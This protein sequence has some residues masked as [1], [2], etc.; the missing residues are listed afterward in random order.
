MIAT[1]DVV[2]FVPAVGIIGLLI[3]AYLGWSIKREK[4]GTKRMEEIAKYI[5]EGANAFLK[6]QYKT[7]SIFIVILTIIIGLTLGFTQAIAFIFGSLLSLLAAYIGINVAVRANVR[8]ANAAR[9]SPKKAFTLAFKGG[10]VMG[11][12]VV[13]LSL[14]GISLLYLVFEK[15]ELIVGFGFGASL[16]ALF[17]QLGGGIYTKA[18]DVGADLVGKVEAHIPED[19]PRNPAVIADQVGD[20]VGDCAGRGAD[21]FESFSDNIICAMILGVLFASLGKNAVIFPLITQAI[22]LI[23]TIVGVF[24]IRGW[25]KLSPVQ[26]FNLGLL[27]VGIIC[28]VGFY[29]A[30]IELLNDI[31]VFYASLAGLIASL[32]VGLVAQYYTG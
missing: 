10:A 16:A 8:T 17:A 5:Q 20:N 11:L 9:K 7:I 12:S 21:L 28:A 32:L 29:F 26:S 31:N 1:S 30:S 18:A 2:F 19:D 3:V 6:R 24:L 4:P 13:S 14:L 25:K 23:A 22:G 27:V 15:P